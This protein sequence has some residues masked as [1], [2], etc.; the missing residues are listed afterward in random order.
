[1]IA[2]L[3]YNVGNVQSIKNMLKK[4]GVQATITNNIN[5]IQNATKLILP[6]VGAYEYG[7]THLN[8]ANFLPVLKEKVTQQKTPILGIC[9]GA[10][11]MLN[12]S[13]EGMPIQGL[14]WVNGTVKKFDVINQG[15]RVPHM[16]WN[17]VAI[18]NIN[19]LVK[20][21]PAD[22]RFYFVHS[23]Y[24]NINNAAEQ[25]LETKYGNT[26]CSGF[27]AGNVYGVQFH[28]EKSHKYGM[29]LLKNFSEL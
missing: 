3:D 6:G 4:I 16:G 11:L 12:G 7:M 9:L 26:F 1:M 2:I 24:F 29:Q 13:E 22:P 25:I 8:N 5:E 19:S 21:L 27:A 23:Y 10:Q 17:D 20:E 18:S 28:P 15:L 14:G